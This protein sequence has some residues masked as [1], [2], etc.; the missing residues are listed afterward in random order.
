M[1]QVQIKGE[2]YNLYDPRTLVNVDKDLAYHKGEAGN[3]SWYIVANLDSNGH[4]IGLH[5]QALIMRDVVSLNLSV[6]NETTQWY[7]SFEY[8][9]NINDIKV[10]T[11]IFEI[12][13]KDFYFSGN[14]DQIIAKVNIPGAAIDIITEKACEPL[15]FNCEGYTDFLGAKQYDFA[16]PRMITK[17]TITMDSEVYHVNGIAWFDRQ[18]GDLPDLSKNVIPAV[19]NKPA[20]HFEGL[21][22]VWLNPQLSNGVNISFGEIVIMSHKLATAFATIAYPDGATTYAPA[23]FL[24]RSD[25][26]ISEA[27]GNKYPTHFILTIPHKNTKLEIN[28]PYKEQEILSKVGNIYE[29]MANINGIFEGEQVTGLAYAEMAGDWKQ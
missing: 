6:V 8:I 4:K 27:T 23:E 11:R 7:K 14:A 17:G 12:E 29:G 26:W 2:T 20:S 1:K 10:N 5:L 16:F 19:G 24:E 15:L 22:W 28:V 13:A 9:Y 21:Q 18:W 3:E 25:F